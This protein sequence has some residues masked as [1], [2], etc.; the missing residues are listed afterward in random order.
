[1]NEGGEVAVRQHGKETAVGT[2]GLDAKIVVDLD[3]DDA[4]GHVRIPRGVSVRYHDGI[5]DEDE[6]ETDGG[7]VERTEVEMRGSGVRED[8]SQVAMV[9]C[10]LL[11]LTSGYLFAI[12]MAFSAGIGLLAAG[13]LGYMSAPA[14][15]SDR[16]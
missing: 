9:A 4:D 13:I 3:T 16:S 11:L 10:V 12:D 7:A 2:P 15:G 8:I 6:L 1:M 5:P 14:W